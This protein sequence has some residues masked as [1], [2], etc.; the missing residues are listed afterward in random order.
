VKWENAW[1]SIMNTFIRHNEQTLKD[2]KVKKDTIIKP[3][4]CIRAH[5]LIAKIMVNVPYSLSAM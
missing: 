5:T 3:L 2:E 1:L 4:T